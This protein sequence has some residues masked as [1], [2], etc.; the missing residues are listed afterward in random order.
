MKTILR[1]LT[2]VAALIISTLQSGFASPAHFND[3]SEKEDEASVN[4]IPYLSLSKGDIVADIGAGGGYFSFKLSEAVGG[5]GRVYSVDISKECTEFISRSA[6]E[7]GITNIQVVLAS[8]D[9]SKLKSGTIDL[10]FIRNTFHDIT[11]RVNYFSKLRSVLKKK[12]RVAVI[13]YD[14]AKLGFFRNLFGHS[15]EEKVIISEMK[16]AGYRLLKSYPFLKQQSFNIF[17]VDN[18]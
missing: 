4:V 1:I 15:L 16:N 7:K 18:D 13:D 6:Q 10:V 8:P 9:D 12:G 17:A 3:L 2:L 11:D 5:S 14:P